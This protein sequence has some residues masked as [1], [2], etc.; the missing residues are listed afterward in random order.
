MARVKEEWR[1]VVGYEGVY[2]V[3]NHGRV[4]RE[5]PGRG[6][7]RG[8]V[9]RP[10]QDG[11]GYLWFALSREGK[12]HI[13]QCHQLVAQAFIGE[14]RGREVNHKNGV[15]DDNRPGNLEFATSKQNSQHAVR[16]GLSPIGERH[17]KTVLT[18]VQVVEIRALR[19]VKTQR[20]VAESFGVSR[21][22]INNIWNGHTW[23][24]A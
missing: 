3:S 24:S 5:A 6:T 2:S 12:R 23:R 9:L 22:A 13:V 21:T 11:N 19:G 8:R 15:K 20:Q 16:T 7:W 17:P 18:N 14:R 1:P 10:A 4:R